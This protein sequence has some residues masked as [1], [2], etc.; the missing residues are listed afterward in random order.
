MQPLRRNDIDI[1]CAANTPKNAFKL[2]PNQ[3]YSIWMVIKG[4]CLIFQFRST[5]LI[6]CF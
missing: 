6:D 1:A 2:A 3:P 4:K 5:H